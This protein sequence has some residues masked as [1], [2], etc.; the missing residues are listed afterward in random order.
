MDA[1]ENIHV[2]DSA[3]NRIQKF[4][5]S[6]TF[7]TKLSSVGNANGMF[8]FPMGIA[9]EATGNVFVS[10]NENHRI[11]KFTAD[12][13]FLDK[14]GK[15]DATG[16]PLPGAGDREFNYPRGIAIDRDG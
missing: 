14:W 1:F 3:N 10:D 2:A 7:I 9:I 8:Y 4:T 16:N 15:V 13:Q 6:G 11:Q 12:G 5:S